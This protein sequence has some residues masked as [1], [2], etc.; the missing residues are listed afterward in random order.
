[1]SHSFSRTSCDGSC[2]G[3]T[4]SHRR[5]SRCRWPG[6]VEGPG[7]APEMPEGDGTCRGCSGYP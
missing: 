3:S 1:V 5:A 2:S 4:T 7:N 6:I